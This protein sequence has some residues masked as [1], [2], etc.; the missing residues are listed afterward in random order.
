MP[1]LVGCLPVLARGSRGR[2]HARRGR[3]VRPIRRT[4]RPLVRGVRRRARR[5]SGRRTSSRV[6]VAHFM[7]GGVK[8]GGSE[9]ELHIGDAYAAIG[10]GDP[11]RDRNTSRSATSTPRRPVPGSPV[12]A[13]VRGLAPSARLRRGRRNQAGRDRRRRD[14]AGSRRSRRCRSSRGRPLVRADRDVGRDRRARRRASRRLPRSHRARRRRSTRTWV[15][16]PRIPSPTWSTSVRTGRPGNAAPAP[17]DRGRA[18]WSSTPTI[19]RRDT[20][21][22]PPSDLLGLFREVLEEVADASA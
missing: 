19:V 13:A 15:G 21:E 9:R 3:V 17:A 1:A 20:G 6:L 11:C 18:T 12:P 16:A 2:L 10:A 8:V 14:R 4:R 7:V 22:E 5:A